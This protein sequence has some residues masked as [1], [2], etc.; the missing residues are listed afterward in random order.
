MD[1]AINVCL[2]CC[3]CCF[4]SFSQHTHLSMCIDMFIALIDVYKR[5][6]KL[7][8]YLIIVEQIVQMHVNCGSVIQQ[9]KCLCMIIAVSVCIESESV[10]ICVLSIA[11]QTLCNCN[12]NQNAFRVV[13]LAVGF[14]S[15]DYFFL[16]FSSKFTHMTQLSFFF[17]PICIKLNL[18]LNQLF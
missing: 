8:Q 1:F 13:L 7:M 18:I 17:V 4:S 16:L 11:K 12:N 15:S 5:N 3:C 14:L 10:F 2:C 6:G 9:I